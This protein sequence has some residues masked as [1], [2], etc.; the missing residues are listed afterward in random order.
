MASS[1]HSSPND[2]ISSPSSIVGEDSTADDTN[3]TTCGIGMLPQQIFS[4]MVQPL[5][6]R[7][8]HQ[9]PTS[10]D[11]NGNDAGGASSSLSAST[12]NYNKTMMSMMKRRT[13]TN[14]NRQVD[15]TDALLAMEFNQ[16]S[17]DARERVLE[18]VHGITQI[19][20]ETQPNFIDDSLCK[21]DSE[22][23]NIKER[24]HYDRAHFLCPSRVRDVNFRLMFLR[25][26]NFNPRNAA[27]RI[28]QHFTYKAE[29]FG[30]FTVICVT[31]ATR[32]R[33]ILMLLM[34]N[35]TT[36]N[37]PTSTGCWTCHHPLF[38]DRY[39]LVCFLFL[40]LAVAA[41]TVSTVYPYVGEEKLIH[42]ITLDDLDEDDKRTL[43][44]GSMQ[45]LPNKDNGGRTVLFLNRRYDNFKS[46]KNQVSFMVGRLFLHPPLSSWLLYQVTNLLSF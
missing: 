25:A 11:I 42:P 9:S 19:A 5:F 30:T 12:N 36:K 14:H 37:T 38:P 31:Y 20:D 41:V 28:V 26:D 2:A 46:W 13:R 15:E 7:Q 6:Q 16:L 8:Q 35:V 29:L 34:C 1:S 32:S 10:S 3:T 22:I 24:W 27:R 43:M 40:L 23:K 4:S 21:L 33:K 18:E 44:S 17:I 45:V 39:F